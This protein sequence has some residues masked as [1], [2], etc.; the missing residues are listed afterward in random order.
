VSATAET[1]S[2]AGTPFFDLSS[3]RKEGTKMSF[4]TPAPGA[5]QAIKASL[6]ELGVDGP[7]R[8]E[9]G[10]AGCCDPSLG[11]AVDAVRETDLVEEWEGLMFVIAPE[12]YEQVGEITI[13][14]IDDGDRCGFVITSSKP[15]SEWEGFGACRIRI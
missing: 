14:P 2:G 15:V 10:F 4:V 5:V 6:A 8:I 11:L 12:V 1:S 7:L 9:L 3:R 13:S